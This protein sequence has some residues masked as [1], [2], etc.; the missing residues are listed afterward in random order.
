MHIYFDTVGK[1]LRYVHLALLPLGLS[2]PKFPPLPL[3]VRYVNIVPVD[4]NIRV[5]LGA[6]P[7]P[8]S[9][10]SPKHLTTHLKA[11]IQ[12]CRFSWTPYFG[13]DLDLPHAPSFCLHD[14]QV[15][16]LPIIN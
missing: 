6:Y 16:N 3:K 2:T 5:D 15:V 4:W 1:A 14:Y 9:P 10:L 13:L 11:R 7:F 12:V 8:S